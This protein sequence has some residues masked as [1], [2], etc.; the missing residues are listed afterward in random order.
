MRHHGRGLSFPLEL[1]LC[2]LFLV[3]A[4]LL[5]LFSSRLYRETTAGAQCNYTQRTVLSYLVNQVRRSDAAGGVSVGRFGEAD[6]L[7]LREEGYVT[8]LYC[9]DGQL[10]ELYTEEG[11]TFAPADGMALLP[12]AD[13]AMDVRPQG[14]GQVLELTGTAPEGERWSV[15]L[16]PRCGIRREAE[17]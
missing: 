13:L 15:A 4:V 5:A 17:S 1:L 7:F 11:L 16:S 8:I 6:A 9:W 3:S 2:T 14:D 10:R 12:L